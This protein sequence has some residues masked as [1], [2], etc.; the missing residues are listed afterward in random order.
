M[1]EEKVPL[2]VLRRRAEKGEELKGI[3]SRDRAFMLERRA[4]KIESLIG[5]AIVDPDFR[6]TLFERTSDIAKEYE[7]DEDSM[8]GLKQ[9]DRSLVDNLAKSFEGKIMKE[10]AD[11]I[12]CAY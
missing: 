3:R 8:E 4:E 6:E 12:F 10:A 7:L 1:V 2:Y 5:K 9:I 11:I